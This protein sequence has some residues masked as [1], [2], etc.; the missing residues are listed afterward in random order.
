MTKASL[1]VLLEQVPDVSL[2]SMNFTLDNSPRPKIEKRLLWGELIVCVDI[3]PIDFT[4]ATQIL[5]GR[6]SV[7]I[8]TNHR[9][10]S[11][12]YLKKER[13]PDFK[14]R[15][16]MRKELLQITASYGFGTRFFFNTIIV[17]IDRGFSKD[18][19]GQTTFFVGYPF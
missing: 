4:T 11:T 2:F 5:E 8:C 7:G 12:F 14:W 6:N 1:F 9:I 13:L 18:E 17:R 15:F 3:V 16:S 19:G 10:H